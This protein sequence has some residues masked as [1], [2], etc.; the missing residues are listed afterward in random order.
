MFLIEQT[1]LINLIVDKIYKERESERIVI[2]L[3]KLVNS[4]LNLPE[5]SSPIE[6]AALVKPISFLLE[7]QEVD[8]EVVLLAVLNLRFL[9]KA[10]V[11][12]GSVVGLLTN[13]LLPRLV[14]WFGRPRYETRRLAYSIIDIIEV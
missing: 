8:S 3:M 1:D 7:N 6:I 13:Y 12:C 2:L 11:R 4:I 9:I 14:L 5:G 10:P